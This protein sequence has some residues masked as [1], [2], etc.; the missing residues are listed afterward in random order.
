LIDP[1]GGA[2]SV[3]LPELL[4][5]LKVDF[6]PVNMKLG[7]FK[8]LIEPK[9]ESLKYLV[10]KIK[11]TNCDFGA[12]WDCDGDRMEMVLSSTSQFAQK[13]G[14]IISGQYVFGLL[15]L[16]VLSNLK[17]PK[18]SWIVVNDA[19]SQ[20]IEKVAEKFGARIKEVE[21]GEINVVDKM[22]QL[23]SPVGGEG[24]S[25]GGIFPPSRCRDG[26]LTLVM[27]LK[28]MAEK[29]KNISD[30]LV[31]LPQYFTPAIK[32]KC[33]PENQKRLKLK[34]IKYFKKLKYPTKKTGGLTG[35]LKIYI[36]KNSWLWY[37]ASKT[38]AGI[39]R[40]IA[41]ARTEKKAYKIISFGKKIF[42]K[43]EK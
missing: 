18:G 25:S 24:S 19:T 36:D 38:E 20:L 32:V 43:L 23:K 8:R 1:N 3:I 2:A 39:F 13:R 28:L 27:L 35:G 34:L 12:A 33:K 11:A 40:I 15:V 29:K 5:K 31:L 26:I 4:K 9:A 37:R 14:N 30:L 21:V 42:R 22:Y 16:E 7:H 6:I 17:N 10:P 41:D